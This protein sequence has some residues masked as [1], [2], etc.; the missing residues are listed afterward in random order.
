MPEESLEA[1]LTDLKNLA[2][3]CELKTLQESLTN[4]M[5]ILGL[6]EENGYIKERLL[7]EGDGKTLEDIMSLARTVEI[8]RQENKVEVMKVYH[9]YQGHKSH[10]WVQSQPST[11]QSKC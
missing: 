4:D 11:S 9:R 3:T 8:S 1:F 10:T 7:Q 5:F 6:K 2:A